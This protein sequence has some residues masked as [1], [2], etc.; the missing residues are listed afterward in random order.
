MGE[1]REG[2][3][4]GRASRPLSVLG[5]YSRGN[6]NQTEGSTQMAQSWVHTPK[7]CTDRHEQV[8]KFESPRSA[9]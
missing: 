8:I 3:G 2:C 6:G 9:E 7:C 4:L 5:F 1:V